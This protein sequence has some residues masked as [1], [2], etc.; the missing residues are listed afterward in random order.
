MGNVAKIT[1]I[2]FTGSLSY[3]TS[4][5]RLLV[6]IMIRFPVQR[7]SVAQSGAA[8]AGMSF[9]TL[10]PPIGIGTQRC[11]CFFRYVEPPTTSDAI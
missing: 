10:R 5:P 1:M 4:S 7:R 9:P 11:L 6:E 8:I 3:A 2:A